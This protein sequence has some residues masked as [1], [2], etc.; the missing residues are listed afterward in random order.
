MSVE[1][2]DLE[3]VTQTYAST[4]EN[5]KSRATINI[6]DIFMNIVVNSRKLG[7]N[8]GALW[9]EFCIGFHQAIVLT[10]RWR[11]PFIFI[12]EYGST[13]NLGLLVGGAIHCFHS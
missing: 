10:C 12:T 9:I 11:H 13:S 1:V 2:I 8:M 3:F 5:L 4:Q 6:Y 7:N